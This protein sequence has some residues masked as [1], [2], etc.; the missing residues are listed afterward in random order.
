MDRVTLNCEDLDNLECDEALGLAYS[1]KNEIICTNPTG[2]CVD[3]VEP[4]CNEIRRLIH[5]FKA[6][7]LIKLNM[8]K[9]NRSLA[10]RLAALDEACA[11]GVALLGQ[12]TLSGVNAEKARLLVNEMDE[13]LDQVDKLDLHGREW[14]VGGVD[15]LSSSFSFLSVEQVS[16]MKYPTNRQREVAVNYSC[17]FIICS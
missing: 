6:S 11:S 13:W 8:I 12:H 14:L 2:Y 7:Y 16:R 9:H 3:S 5:E 1:P 10:H 17:L 4:K 15:Q